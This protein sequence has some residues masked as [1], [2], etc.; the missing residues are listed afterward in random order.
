MGGKAIIIVTIGL[1]FVLGYISMNLS[2][3]ATRSVENMSNY[4]MATESH[5]LA[6][7]G[8]NVG[9]SKFYGDTSWSGTMTQSFYGGGE[10]N[11]LGNLSGSFT[12]TM[13]DLTPT[14]ARLRSVSTYNSS[15]EGSIHDTVEVF[16][17]T[18]QEN[19]FSLYA[20]LTGFEGNDDFWVT[21]DTIWG[22]AHSNGNVHVNGKPVF[23]GKF[24]VSKGFDP[25]PGVGTNKAV[26][27]GGYETGVATVELPNDLSQIEWAANNGGRFYN[28]DI[29]VVLS[30][31]T[32]AN[33]DGFA[34]ILA[35]EGGP[36][37]DTVNINDPGFNGVI[38]GEDQVSILG[39]LDGQLTIASQNDIYVQ[40]NIIYENRDLTT[41]DDVLGLVADHS[42]IIANSAPNNP[43]CEIDGSIFARSGSFEVEDITSGTP[44]GNLKVKG[45]IVQATKGK[46]GTYAGG[47]L[48]K[49][50]AAK[51]RYDD[52]LA[53]NSFRPPFYP[54]YGVKTYE[55]SNWWENVRIPEYAD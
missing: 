38:M 23:Y 15:G 43:D 49:G 53:D 32:G 16:F 55:I 22:R 17:D 45:S 40:D 10:D 51:Y 42:V 7:T 14:S 27:K 28:G 8:A 29:W 39:T 30:G 36:V 52:R 41:S 47:T 11:P 25:K 34:I 1:G 2:G 18:E 13:E 37:L 54:G 19:G 33:E 9:L 31:S 44:R 5:N 26:Y 3:M 6:I 35:S 46:T 48:K 50:Y 4:A 21:G 24:T 12:V 20:W